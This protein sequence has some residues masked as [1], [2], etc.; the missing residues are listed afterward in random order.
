MFF[1]PLYVNKNDNADEKLYLTRPY[2]IIGEY[3]PSVFFFSP[4][5]P[6]LIWFIN[7]LCQAMMIPQQVLV[8][9]L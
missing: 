7:Y 3:Y 2:S 1:S 5:T 9:L 4:G 8:E 6:F